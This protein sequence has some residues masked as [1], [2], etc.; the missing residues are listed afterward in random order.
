MAVLE[1]MA[2]GLATVSTNVGGIPQVIENGTDGIRFDAGNIKKIAE[3]LIQ[4]LNDQSEKKRLGEA[5]RA[6]IESRF[7]AQANI[8]ALYNLY[9]EVGI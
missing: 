4:L 5:G 9:Q 7:S 1:A 8:N 6:K 2:H 3:I